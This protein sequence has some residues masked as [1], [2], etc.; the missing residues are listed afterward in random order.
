MKKSIL[1]LFMIPLL[2]FKADHK[3]YIALTE[4]EFNKKEQAIQM[5]MN[6][7]VDDIEVAL[8]D[9]FTIDS[10]ISNHDELLNLD[11]Y[12][13]SYLNNHFKIKINGK[14]KT[15]NFI[16]KEYDGNIVYF[17]LEIKNISKVK[18][19]EIKNTVLIKNFTDQQNLIKAKVNGN[20][21]SLFLTKKNY[22]G[23][24]NF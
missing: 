14:E 3:Y 2:S 11:N 17:Y 5:I 1:L 6:V 24:L 4:I 7:F 15:Y 18:S 13:H 12:F 10:Q 9:E 20:R 8:N 16:G 19:I 21:K 22:K 23:L